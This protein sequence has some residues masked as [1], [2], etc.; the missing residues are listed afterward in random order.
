MAY[1]LLSS[2]GTA[3]NENKFRTQRPTPFNDPGTVP[4]RLASVP[5]EKRNEPPNPRPRAG[6]VRTRKRV[7]PRNR[8]NNRKKQ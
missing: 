3:Q 8:W 5:F 7:V 4:V 2:T 1:H 6:L